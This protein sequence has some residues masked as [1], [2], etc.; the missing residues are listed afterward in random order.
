[1]LYIIENTILINKP[2][3]PEELHGYTLRYTHE[4]SG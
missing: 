2:F 4:E 1:M 3:A